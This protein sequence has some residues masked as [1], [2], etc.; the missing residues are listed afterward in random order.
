MPHKQY[1]TAKEVTDS[2]KVIEATERSSIKTG[3]LRAIGIGKG[4]RIADQDLNR[5]MVSH[6]TSQRAD[7]P[8]E[9]HPSSG[10]GKRCRQ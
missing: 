10:S 7:V 4:W 2:L 1:Q 6:Q 8:A 5:F 3:A 9:A